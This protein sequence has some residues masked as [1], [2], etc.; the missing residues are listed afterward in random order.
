MEF[1]QTCLQIP[2]SGFSELYLQNGNV[3][4]TYFAGPQGINDVI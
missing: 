4:N 1:G 3:K 2:L